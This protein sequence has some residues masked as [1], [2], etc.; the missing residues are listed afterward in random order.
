MPT[1]RLDSKG[2][3]LTEV[4]Q[5]QT[6]I[7][8]GKGRRPIKESFASQL[9]CIHRKALLS[10]PFTDGAQSKASKAKNIHF[11]RKSPPDIEKTF[12][13]LTFVPQLP[14]PAGKL[15]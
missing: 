5:E 3:I 9:S 4:S 11:V 2:E 7:W 8:L 10:M 6:E 13:M 12:Q 15:I 1:D 14:P